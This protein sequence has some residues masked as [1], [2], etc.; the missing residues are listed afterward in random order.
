M[1]D[2]AQPGEDDPRESVKY[3]PEVDL[4]VLKRED[5]R[6]AARSEG[7]SESR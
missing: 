5:A 2:R 1:T 4:A 3:C 6:I 7:S